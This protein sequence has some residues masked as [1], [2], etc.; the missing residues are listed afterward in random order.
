MCDI[1]EFRTQEKRSPAC[2]FCGDKLKHGRGLAWGHDA[3]PV[4][5]GR[6]CDIC[7]DK[8]VLPSEQFK[9]RREEALDR[10]GWAS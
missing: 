4:S 6:C 10:T 2:R 5:G 3:W 9:L 8:I 7:H 1:C